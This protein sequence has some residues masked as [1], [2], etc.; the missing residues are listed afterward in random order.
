M[1]INPKGDLQANSYLG[2]SFHGHGAMIER[3]EHLKRA[4]YTVLRAPAM[5]HGDT[6]G[7]QMCGDLLPKMSKNEITAN[8]NG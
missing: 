4:A 6:E 3:G 7:V 8:L 2:T 5:H 1:P